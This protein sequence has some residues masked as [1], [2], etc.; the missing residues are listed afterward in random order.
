[1]EYQFTSDKPIYLQ[2]MD[3]FKVAIV[4]GE[5]PK[6]ERLES[7]RDLAIVAKVNPNTM[8]KALAELERIGLVRTERTSGRFIT[9]DEDLI[10]SMKKELAEKEIKEFLEK[11]KQMGLTKDTV[12]KM[13]SEL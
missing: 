2:L 9:D 10:L 13:I 5:L 8:Q 1:M 11:M 6:G 4:S 7:V 3:V 12:I